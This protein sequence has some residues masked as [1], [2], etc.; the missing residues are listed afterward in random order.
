VILFNASVFDV[1]LASDV[2]LWLFKLKS[3]VGA[4]IDYNGVV[5]NTH[6]ESPFVVVV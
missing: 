3:A 4:K 5:Y 1:A 6:L 2:I